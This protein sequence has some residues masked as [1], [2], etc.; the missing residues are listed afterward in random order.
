MLRA[1]STFLSFF[2]FLLLSRTRRCRGSG[3][4]LSHKSTRRIKLLSERGV[5]CEQSDIGGDEEGRGCVFTRYSYNFTLIPVTAIRNWE[6]IREDTIGAGEHIH[7]SSSTAF[8]RTSANAKDTSWELK[9]SE[10]SSDSSGTLARL[11]IREGSLSGF[12]VATHLF[13]Y[14]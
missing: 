11:C 2:F 3:A 13:L 10:K 6:L 12:T 9:K 4:E 7:R 14:K 5:K 1:R 8:P